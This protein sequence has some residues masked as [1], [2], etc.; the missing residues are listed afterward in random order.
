MDK[1]DKEICMNEIKMYIDENG[2]KKYRNSKGEL[3]RLDGPAI[4]WKNGD[5]FWCKEGKFHREDGPAWDY[6]N[7]S[8]FWYKEGV[9]H[10]LNGPAVEYSSESK[11]WHILVLEFEEKDFNS[12]INRIK[13]FI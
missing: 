13:K 7:G 5:K 3:H 4:E 1:S 6:I 9:L 10:R 11:S 12:W 8:K 2:T